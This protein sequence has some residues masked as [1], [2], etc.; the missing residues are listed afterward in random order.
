MADINIQIKQRNE[1]NTGWDNIY[2]KTKGEVV[3]LSDGKTA[4]EH[5]EDSSI[6]VTTVKKLEWDAKAST[7][8]VEQKVAELVSSAPSALNTLNELAQALGDDPNFATTITNAIASKIDTSK[9]D[10]NTSL[11]TSNDKVPSQKA[12]KAYIDNS[13][14]GAGNGDMLKSVYDTNNNGKVD[15]AEFADRASLITTSIGSEPSNPKQG[16][17]WFATL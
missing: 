3:V 1:D 16:E 17:V 12:V 2:P 8:Y 15:K 7:A 14:S 13:M 6:H 4:Q 11:G 10:T 9:I 5:A